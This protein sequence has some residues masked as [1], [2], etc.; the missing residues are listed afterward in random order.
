MVYR[1]RLS[2]LKDN[3]GHFS[4][5]SHMFVSALRGFSDRVVLLTLRHL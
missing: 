3:E 1:L 4:Y 5:P 2:V